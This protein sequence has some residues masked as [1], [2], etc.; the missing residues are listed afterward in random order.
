[1]ADCPGTLVHFCARTSGSTTVSE[2]VLQRAE[3]SATY[4]YV[5]DQSALESDLRCSQH[6]ARHDV[7]GDTVGCLEA[8][9]SAAARAALVCTGR[10]AARLLSTGLLLVVAGL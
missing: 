4:A 7:G 10:W 6:R 8:G 9:V 2:S 3:D 5:L 1:M